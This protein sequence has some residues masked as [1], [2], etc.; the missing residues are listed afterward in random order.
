MTK[1][2]IL[3]NSINSLFILLLYFCFLFSYGKIP[4]LENKITTT[5]INIEKINYHLQCQ[6]KSDTIVINYYQV[7][8]LKKK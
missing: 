8:N 5:E 3:W 2:S 7:S 1:G 6:S 4:Y